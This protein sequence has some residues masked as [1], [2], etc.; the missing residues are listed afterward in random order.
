MTD[1]WSP[2]DAPPAGA[3]AQT[4]LAKVFHTAFNAAAGKIVLD[5]LVEITL[6][7]GMPASCSDAELRQMEG[8]R[9]LVHYIRAMV[10]RAKQE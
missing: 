5:H 3:A 8:K 10:A 4:G 2:F 1:N 9:E 6:D 7:R